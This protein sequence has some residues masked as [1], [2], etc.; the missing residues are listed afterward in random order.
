MDNQRPLVLINK[1]NNMYR[2][3][4]STNNDEENE[5]KKVNFKTYDRIVFLYIH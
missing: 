4:K 1:K 3:W 5:N 2:N